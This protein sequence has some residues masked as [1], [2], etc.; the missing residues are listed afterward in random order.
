MTHG[1]EDLVPP[2]VASVLEKAVEDVW[3]ED[4]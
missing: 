3:N 4:T 1:G 2:V